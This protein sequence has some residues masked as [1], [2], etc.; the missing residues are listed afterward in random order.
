LS[1]G[2]KTVIYS[3]DGKLIKTKLDKINPKTSSGNLEKNN[4]N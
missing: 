1:F 4:R 3:D 2:F